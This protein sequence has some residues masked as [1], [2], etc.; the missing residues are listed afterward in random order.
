MQP[1]HFR[2]KDR[3]IDE[4]DPACIAPLSRFHS[5]NLIYEIRQYTVINSLFFLSLFVLVINGRR[6]LAPLDEVV[7][8]VLLTFQ[9]DLIIGRLVE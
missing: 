9:N 1:H 3:G 2:A 4:S 6:K 5:R 8:E 7:D